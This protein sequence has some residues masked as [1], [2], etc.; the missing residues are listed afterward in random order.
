[1][2][3]AIFQIIRNSNEIS[4]IIIHLEILIKGRAND[5]TLSVLNSNGVQE[6]DLLKI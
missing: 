3:S 5:F 1:V 6:S 2:K 4:K